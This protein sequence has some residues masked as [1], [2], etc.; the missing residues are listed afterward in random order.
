MPGPTTPAPEPTPVSA[1]SVFQD[2]PRLGAAAHFDNGTKQYR[3]YTQDG[4]T[5]GDL[6]Q[7]RTLTQFVPGEVYF[8]WVSGAVM[9][10]G[11]AL[12]CGANCMNVV[13]W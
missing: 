9:V 10:N 4:W 7:V 8:L 2:T 1:A 13:V 3:Y 12:T 6:G 5:F 11:H